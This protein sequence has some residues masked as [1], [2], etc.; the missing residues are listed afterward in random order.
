M[1]NKETVIKPIVGIRSDDHRAI[2]FKT[3]E[4]HGNDTSLMLTIEDSGGS[5]SFF[6][7][8]P[9]ELVIFAQR[10]ADAASNFEPLN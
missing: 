2:E 3:M 5:A 8:H 10:V 4:M 6:F 1:K 9:T 7:D